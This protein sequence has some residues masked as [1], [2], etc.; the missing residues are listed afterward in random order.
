MRVRLLS[1]AVA[2]VLCAI[3]L[4][5]EA[6]SVGGCPAPGGYLA[7][8]FGDIPDIPAD[9]FASQ[10]LNGDGTL[11]AKFSPSRDDAPGS[12]QGILIDNRVRGAAA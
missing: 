9:F 7:I 2:T 8:Q 3:P 11:C 1:A 4:P 12:P 5:A 6:E 10:D